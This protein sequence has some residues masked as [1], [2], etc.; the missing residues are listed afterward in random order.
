MKAGQFTNEQIVAILQEAQ[1]A[2]KPILQICKE[3][4][5]TRTR[6]PGGDLLRG[7]ASV[8]ALAQEVRR[9]AGPRRAAPARAIAFLSDFARR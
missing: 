3:K 6:V 7:H 9:D 5:I 2:D 4:G 1:K 8:T